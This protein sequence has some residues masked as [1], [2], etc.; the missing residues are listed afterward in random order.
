MF[1][2]GQKENLHL[3]KANTAQPASSHGKAVTLEITEIKNILPLKQENIS[4]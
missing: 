1:A 3:G 2:L 4:Y